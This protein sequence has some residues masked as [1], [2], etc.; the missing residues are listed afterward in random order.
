VPA[1][2]NCT[3]PIAARLPESTYP[4]PVEDAVLL[5]QSA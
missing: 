2:R 5:K 4:P 1:D 3:S